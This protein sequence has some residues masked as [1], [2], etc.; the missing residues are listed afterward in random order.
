[1]VNEQAE[2]V[3]KDKLKVLEGIEL[4]GEINTADDVL[5][6][7][8]AAAIRRGHPQ[9][10]PTQLQPHRV[11]LV[12][13]GPSLASTLPELRELV[14]EGAMLVTVNGAYQWCLERNL[15]PNAQVVIDARPENARFV[16]PDVPGC[17]YY[18]AS[19]CH[20][21]T[22]DAVHGRK[23]VGIFHATDPE[24]ALKEMLDEYYLG[25]WTGI[26]GGTT[27]ASRA[28]ALLRTLGY[29]RF[30][31]FGVD[32]CWLGDDHHA[33]AQPENERDRKRRFTLRVSPT[34]DDTMWREFVVSPWHVKQFED[35]LQFIRV[36][37]QHVLLNVHGDGL[38]AY[39]LR[40]GSA[41]S[42][43]APE[44]ME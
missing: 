38:L 40:A 11:A 10:W 16:E 3:D 33:Y 14:F 34:A 31:L 24:G 4:L 39:A 12:G 9:V 17:R 35:F 43:S 32:S 7:Q 26:S 42:V 5:K 28:L 13:G 8:V 27:V 23:Y 41:V 6:E 20:A 25:C 29:L 22:W 36:N 37:G 19:Q 2:V 44:R 21:R 15:K 18:L 30:D 1:M